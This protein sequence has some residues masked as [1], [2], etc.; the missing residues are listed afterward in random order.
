[1]AKPEYHYGLHAVEAL[2]SSQ[3]EQVLGLFILQGREDERIAKMVRQAEP[4]GVSVQKATRSTLA[5]L[6]FTDVF[7]LDG[8]LKAWSAAGMPVEKG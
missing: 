1:M 4:L 7:T 5:K 8:G 6:G 3:P 2:L